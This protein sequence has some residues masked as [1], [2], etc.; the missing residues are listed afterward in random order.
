MLRSSGILLP[1]T[2]LPS[3]YGI[4]TMG[5]AAYSFVDFLAKAG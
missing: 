1:L 3:R 5:R 2:A 4:G